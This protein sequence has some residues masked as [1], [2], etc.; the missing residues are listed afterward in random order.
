V[1]LPARAKKLVLTFSRETDGKQK[2]SKLQVGDPL[3]FGIV[4]TG[5]TVA[6]N[7]DDEDFN[8]AVVSILVKQ[9][10]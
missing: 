9:R 7:G 4:Q 8:D 2:T 3:F 5:I 10:P 6:E 1:V